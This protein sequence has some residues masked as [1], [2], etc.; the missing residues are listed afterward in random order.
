MEMRNIRYQI[1]LMLLTGIGLISCKEAIDIKLKNAAPQLIIEGNLI[2]LIGT[3]TITISRTVNFDA[4][5]TFP[6]VSGASVKVT[7]NNTGAVYTYTERSPGVY[8]STQIFGRVRRNYTLRA[9]VDG[10]TYTASSTMPADR[11]PIDSV[12]TSDPAFGDDETKTVT[13]YY[14]DPPGVKNFYRFVMFVNGVQV[15]NI[16]VRNDEYSDGRLVNSRLYQNDIKIKSGDRVDVDMQG[17]DE[18]LYNYWYTFAQQNNFVG[19][20]ATP[21]NPV[22]NFDSPVLG[23][24][25][26]RTNFRRS[27]TVR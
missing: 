27:F 21:T 2:D 16:F 15:K 26:V 3:Q 9:I 22:N 6:A 8:T 20:S 14:H 25:S 11:V 24:F 13:L 18:P 12:T 7:D 5:N 4:P 23:Y 1:L 17:L 19:G 10:K